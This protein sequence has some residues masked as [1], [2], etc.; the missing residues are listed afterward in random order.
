MGAW[1]HSGIYGA[2]KAHVHHTVPRR[3]KLFNANALKL[4]CYRPNKGWSCRSPAR[5][6]T[7][8]LRTHC[9]EL[10]Y[11]DASRPINV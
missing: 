9:Q 3:D 1:V 4:P 7:L 11:I 2:S 5:P 8:R 6:T 10:Y